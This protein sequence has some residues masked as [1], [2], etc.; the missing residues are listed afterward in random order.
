MPGVV[1]VAYVGPGAV[2]LFVGGFLGCFFG[3]RLFRLVLGI[4]GF[5]LGAF[6]AMSLTGS[7]ETGPTV[8][9]AL[10]GGLLG[11]LLL[12]L[13]YYLGLALVGA[14]LGA[15]VASAIW[16]QL[17]SE[18]H[19]LVVIALAIAGAFT[20]LALQ[21]YVII[22]GTAF[23]GAWTMI[24][25]GL[26]LMGNSHAAEA[27]GRNGVWSAYPWYPGA[28]GDDAVVVGWLVLGAAGALVQLV[29][30]SRGR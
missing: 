13:A 9:A 29:V 16:S 7:A 5:V 18:P 6:L 28:S 21:R 25:G 1:P 4:Y 26:A 3:Y 10:V 19:V 11:A 15:I 8:V 2:L 17:G 12:I 20:A 30:T 27:A 22:L 14:A 23:G 24:V